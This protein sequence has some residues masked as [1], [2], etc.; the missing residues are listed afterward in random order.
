MANQ[1]IPGLSTLSLPSSAAMLWINDPSANPQDRS[2]S[3]PRLYS[4]LQGKATPLAA[5]ASPYTPASPWAYNPYIVTTGGSN[6]TFNLPAATGS[7]L[8][9]EI[10]KADSGVGMIVIVPNGTNVID[11]AGN[12][13]VYLGYQYQ[14]IRLTDI[15]AGYWEVTLLGKRTFASAS[16]VFTVLGGLDSDFILTAAATPTLPANPYPGQRI[17]FK[18]KTTALTTVTANSGQTIG[19]TGSTTFPL[20]AQDDYVTLEFDGTSIW[21]VMATNGPVLVSSQTG[22]TNANTGGSWAA[23]GNG[24]ALNGGSALPVGVYDLF[25]EVTTYTIGNLMGVAIGNVNTPISAIAISSY[26][27]GGNIY[28]PQTVGVR[29]YAL[30]VAAVIQGIFVT[31][32]GNGQVIYG[33][34]VGAVGKITARRIG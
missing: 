27:P 32:G 28:A 24:L 3:L 34:S 10:K 11:K 13:N 29:G 15:A 22:T 6:F 21:Y 19:T 25:L 20:Y 23:I 8:Q 30:N 9:L 31:F 16:G 5:G 18:N 1:T 12:A 4:W 33:G 17:T 2:I 7:G 14:S 26:Q